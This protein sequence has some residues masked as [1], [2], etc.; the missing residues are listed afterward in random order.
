MDQPSHDDH[1][2]LPIGDDIY[3]EMI[4]ELLVD[5]SDDW[6]ML[7]NVASRVQQNA[8]RHDIE[9]ATSDR[10][11]VGIEVLQRVIQSGLMRPG[12][13][14][15]ETHAF[16]PWDLSDSEAIE[17]IDEGWRLAGDHLQMG[18]VCWLDNT[19][20]GLR[21]AERVHAAVCARLGWP[22]SNRQ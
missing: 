18:D 3:E 6:L 22:P 8:R 1:R 21:H 2:R 16:V 7:T 17:R 10:I 5:G 4:D 11:T 20:E 13:I 14:A 15:P 9:L 12:D 19:A